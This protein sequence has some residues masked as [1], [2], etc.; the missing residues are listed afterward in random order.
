MS[1]IDIFN[2]DADGICALQQLR[3]AQP[4]QSELITG[5]KRDIQLLNNLQVNNSDEIAVMDISFDKN[6]DDVTRL[7]QQG[8]KIQYFDHHFAGDIPQSDLLEVHIYTD[9][10]TCT[11]LIMNQYLDAEFAKWA[12]VGAFG[13]NLDESAFKLAKQINMDDQSIAE[14]KQLGICLNYNGYGF[15]IDDLIFHPKDLYLK[16]KSYD[17][18]NDFISSDFTYK[19]LSGQYFK[20]LESAEFTQPEHQSKNVD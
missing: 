16:L 1:Q 17:D 9:A 2:G 6:R 5:L 7:N 14:C 15:A 11:S 3:L 18:P 4:K 13:D 19:E 20:D 12:V 8:V 10:N